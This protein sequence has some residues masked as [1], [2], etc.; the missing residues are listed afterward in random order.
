MM[1]HPP[2]NNP[3][4]TPVLAPT[5]GKAPEFKDERYSVSTLYFSTP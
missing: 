4:S 1:M 2:E 3:V 5:G